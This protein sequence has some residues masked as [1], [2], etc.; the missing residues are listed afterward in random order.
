M[1]ENVPVVVATACVLHNLCEI[2]G[3]SFDDSWSTN[4]ESDHLSQPDIRHSSDGTSGS[5]GIRE[6]FSTFFVISSH[7]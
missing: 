7:V 4:T 5:V 6:S 2:H 3:E 1:V